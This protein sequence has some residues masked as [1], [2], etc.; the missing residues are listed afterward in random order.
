MPRFPEK[1]T[2]LSL[3]ILFC[4]CSFPTLAAEEPGRRFVVSDARARVSFASAA[5]ESS[6][7]L[8]GLAEGFSPQ[9]QFAES[10][11][12]PNPV[13]TA[14]GSGSDSTFIRQV[15]VE[16]PHREP[17]PEPLP[18]EPPQSPDPDDAEW[19]NALLDKPLAMTAGGTGKSKID[20][21]SVQTGITPLISVVGSLLIV[22]S[23]FML[24]ML[25][26][27]K[28]SPKGNRLLPQ[29]AFEN[30]GRTFLTSKLQLHLLR[31]G[32]RLI[33]VSVTPDGVSPVTEITDPDEVVPLLGLCRRLDAHSA[34][35]LFRK[36]LAGF[37]SGNDYFGTQADSDTPS[38]TTM[39]AKK[40]AEAKS[41]GLVDLY[42]ESD[43]SLADLLAA[44]LGSKGGKHG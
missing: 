37:S 34:T 41:F 30:L 1:N 36:T 38:K 6:R 42:S 39:P 15:S 5:P 2:F 14:H 43:E 23:A 8:K 12:T 35:E 3:S 17:R 19:K 22:L 13:S 18:S 28:V 27:K 10:V 33:L 16:M 9:A 26:F 21:P 44:G 29:E 25:L 7:Q 40:R 20:K 4:V 32:N 31:L 11:A 24:L